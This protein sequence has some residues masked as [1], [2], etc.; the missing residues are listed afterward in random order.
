MF[1]DAGK[2]MVRIKSTTGTAKFS[3]PRTA[4]VKALIHYM[5]RREA[6]LLND[7]A[8]CQADSKEKLAALEAEK[9][10]LVIEAE[11]YKT[12]AGPTIETAPK[13]SVGEK[14]IDVDTD[15]PKQ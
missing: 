5:M 1:S 12:A 15:T 10:K 3:A 4:T 9:K 7:V 13:E 2:E 6:L 14:T 11:L 8:M